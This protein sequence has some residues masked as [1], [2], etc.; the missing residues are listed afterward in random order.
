M[1]ITTLSKPQTRPRQGALALAAERFEEA[2]ADA[3]RPGDWP[4]HLVDTFRFFARGLSYD[5]AGAQLFIARDTVKIR[6]RRIRQRLGVDG[7]QLTALAGLAHRIVPPEDVAAPTELPRPLSPG[8][9]EVLAL[10][11]SGLS[12]RETAAMLG[13]PST[14]AKSRLQY[15]CV[16]L[17]M[18]GVLRAVVACAVNGFIDVPGVPRLHKLP[19]ADTTAS[20]PPHQHHQTGSSTP[21]GPASPTPCGERPRGA[22]AVALVVAAQRQ[23]TLPVHPGGTTATPSLN[24]RTS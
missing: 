5:Q 18:P 21:V 12:P 11:A 23:R 4:P 2:F 17:G 13:I 8:E 16:T 10:R 1:T 6:L 9:V 7:R 24:R 14:T 3:P 20:A 15:S 22:T 19:A